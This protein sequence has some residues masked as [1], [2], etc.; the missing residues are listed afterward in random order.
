MLKTH[1]LAPFFLLDLCDLLSESCLLP[2]GNRASWQ[3][4]E[5]QEGA[6]Y[7]AGGWQEQ[8]EEDD[9]YDK[10]EQEHEDRHSDRTELEGAPRHWQGQWHLFQEAPEPDE[11]GQECHRRGCTAPPLNTSS[12]QSP[13]SAWPAFGDR[14]KSVTSL[15]PGPRDRMMR[16]QPP[17]QAQARTMA[18]GGSAARPT[19]RLAALDA[20]RG[21]PE[22]AVAM[23]TPVPRIQ[24]RQETRSSEDFFADLEATEQS[25][26]APVAKQSLPTSPPRRPPS[27]VLPPSASVAAANK[28]WAHNDASASTPEM[29]ALSPQQRAPAP[30]TTLRNGKRALNDDS[31]QAERTD[32]LTPL[33]SREPLFQQGR[34]AA[35]SED[36]NK[37][38]GRA[39]GFCLRQDLRHFSHSV[40][41]QQQHSWPPPEQPAA[42]GMSDEEQEESE[43]YAPPRLPRWSQHHP[44]INMTQQQ[45]GDS[46]SDGDQ[47]HRTKRYRT[48]AAEGIC[49]VKQSAWAQFLG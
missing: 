35:V 2:P 39:A 13:I 33:H 45:D 15:S 16:P 10:R 20:R 40:D 43:F 17:L 7:E 48:K 29:D 5:D 31:W 37:I 23:S 21:P 27:C 49:L 38:D 4:E 42:A 44:P 18:S 28:L 22:V 1:P 12:R 6:D 34:H 32:R 11:N 26:P 46:D 36:K 47:D 3:A 8:G 30:P 25:S 41:Q 14:Q 19:I 9:W 24:E